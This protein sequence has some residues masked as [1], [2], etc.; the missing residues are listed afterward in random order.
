MPRQGVTRA[1]Q[2][3]CVR[4]MGRTSAVQLIWKRSSNRIANCALAMAHSRSGI[5]HSRSARF[6]TRNKSFSAASSVGKWPRVLTARRSL[7]FRASMA[8]VA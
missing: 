7:A 1:C 2:E 4:A 5:L 3:F 8:F 6:K